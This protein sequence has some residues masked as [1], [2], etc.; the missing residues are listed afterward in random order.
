MVEPVFIK[1]AYPTKAYILEIT[2]AVTRAVHLKLVSEM[3]T[4][5][6]FMAFRRFISRCDVPS[7]V[8]SDNALTAKKASR[9]F[10]AIFTL[11]QSVVIKDY[12]CLS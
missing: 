8:Y 6:F 2:F 4:H 7:V 5:S 11:S 10:H 9:E 3:S 12:R 1:D